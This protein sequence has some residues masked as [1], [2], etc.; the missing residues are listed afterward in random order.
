MRGGCWACAVAMFVCGG[1][2]NR[3][4]LGVCLQVKVTK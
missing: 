4:R 1:L 2:C 3:I